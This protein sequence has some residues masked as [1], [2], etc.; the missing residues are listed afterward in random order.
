MLGHTQRL[1]G[2][3]RVTLNLKVSRGQGRI[4]TSRLLASPY[5]HIKS[6]EVDFILSAITFVAER[7][8]LFLPFYRLNHKLGR[9]NIVSLLDF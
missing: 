3:L 1:L 8:W 2:Q 7:G 6:C 5:R 4:A 9:S